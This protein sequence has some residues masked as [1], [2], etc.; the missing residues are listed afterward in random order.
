MSKTKKKQGPV[1]LQNIW[2]HLDP[3]IFF[4][5]ILVYSQAGDFLPMWDWLFPIQ[6][7]KCDIFWDAKPQPVTAA[8]EGLWYRDPLQKMYSLVN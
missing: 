3:D 8:N 5:L 6:N 2:F 4:L 7:G 1:S